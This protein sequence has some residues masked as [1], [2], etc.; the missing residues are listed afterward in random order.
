MVEVLV[1]EGE[2]ERDAQTRRISG[3][4]RDHRLVHLSLPAELP[5]AQRPRPGDLVTTTITRA[6]PHYLI[7][8]SALAAPLGE[9]SPEQFSVRRTF[10]G[11]AW[12]AGVRGSDGGA[13]CGTGGGGPAGPVSLGLPSLRVR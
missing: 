11:D 12:E 9:L 2:G 10:S 7:S 5:A 8:D 4:A 6:A 1:A 3:R 13:S